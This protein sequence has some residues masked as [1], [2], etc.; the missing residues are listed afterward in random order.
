MSENIG[1][2]VF[3]VA[4]LLSCTFGKMYSTGMAPHRNKPQY[5]VTKLQRLALFPVG[6]LSIALGVTRLLRK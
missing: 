3:G 4:I 1:L 2:I 6:M 5:P